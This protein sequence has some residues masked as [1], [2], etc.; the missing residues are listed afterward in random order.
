MPLSGSRHP[1]LQSPLAVRL[2][3][4]TIPKII[5]LYVVASAAWSVAGWLVVKVSDPGRSWLEAARHAL[6]IVWGPDNV[7]D[8]T[9]TSIGLYAFG[10]LNTVVTVLL[11]VLLL[12]AFV[13][14][15]FRHDPIRWRTSITVEAHT[16]GNYVLAARFYNSFK[17]PVADLRVRA[18]LRWVPHDNQS[19]RRNKPLDLVI[20]P[21]VVDR[22]RALP[23][24]TPAEPTT[25][26]VVVCPTARDNHALVNPLQA[27]GFLDIQG[28]RAELAAAAVVLVV[29]GIVTA[30]N[31]PF[32]STMSYDLGTQMQ[33]EMFQ[34]VPLDAMSGIE[35]ER[36]DET[37]E[38]YMFV[39]GSLMRL[40]DLDKAGIH[41]DKIQQV[42]LGG[43]TRAWNV[44][45]DPS[46]KG[47][48]YYY[49]ADDQAEELYTGHIVSLGL[50]KEAGAATLGMAVKVDFQTLA[51]FDNRERD[52][53]R[54]DVTRDIIWKE[55][56]TGPPIRVFA[57]VPKVR[58][59]EK[60]DALLRAN[61]PLVIVKSY[62]DSTLAAARTRGVEFEINFSDAV[63]ETD[64]EIRSMRRV[65][66]APALADNGPT[67]LDP[68]IEQ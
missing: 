4:F 53:D 10:L 30:S 19:V 24:A 52:Y 12:G 43:W 11:P 54:V 37:Q 2:S 8:G 17:V 55:P 59:C 31:E 29:D 35:W 3:Q 50:R 46:E 34:D 58:A 66:P 1:I 28:V 18:W 36:F 49:E 26:R 64:I 40:D 27:K 13:F 68:S 61:E 23:L 15:L 22:E 21:G 25:V 63:G 20:A 41:P 39:Y 16:S 33:M 5:V 7:F 67:D 65:D 42:K 57:Y 62:Y 6:W 60:F 48:K 9:T 32:R 45:S 38:I 56:P 51:N 14:K 44:A 47:R